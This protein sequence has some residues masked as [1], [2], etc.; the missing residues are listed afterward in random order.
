MFIKY[1]MLITKLQTKGIRDSM[2]RQLELGGDEDKT[3]IIITNLPTLSVSK[4]SYEIQN[5][6]Q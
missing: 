1:Q 5:T 2:L 3:H 4:I 6:E